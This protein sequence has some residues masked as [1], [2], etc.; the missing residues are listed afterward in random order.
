MRLDQLHKL[1]ARAIAHGARPSSD[2]PN[3]LEWDVS[4]SC[5]TPVRRVLHARSE[6]AAGDMRKSRV[7][8]GSATLFLQVRCRKC[9]A[10]LKYKSAEWRRRCVAE[11]KVAPRTWMATLTYSADEHFKARCAIAIQQR[12]RGVNLSELDGRQVFRLQA[13]EM[14]AEFTK[15]V[16]RLRKGD[17]KYPPAS[18]RYILATE[19][20]QS[21]FPHLH[22]LIHETDASTPVRKDQL[23]RHWHRGFS[24]FKLVDGSPR[25][26]F[27]VTK[28]INKSMMTRVRA[29]LGYGGVNTSSDIGEGLPEAVLKVLY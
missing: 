21:G 3:V 12:K 23:H 15:Y 18:L 6:F 20:H 16:K 8:P 22:A 9:E 28:Y 26:A 13:A 27:Y 29:S 2:M 25:S 14:G 4:A 19:A 11:L 24:T 1:M 7:N 5:L 10:C 17:D